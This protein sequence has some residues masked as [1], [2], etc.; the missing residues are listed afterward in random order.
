MERSVEYPMNNR[1]ITS[2]FSQYGGICDFIPKKTYTLP[3]ALSYS[4]IL[5][6]VF[7]S[8]HILIYILC[9][10]ILIL[11]I[12]GEI[13][14]DNHIKSLLFNLLQTLNYGGNIR[15]TRGLPVGNLE[16]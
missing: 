10:L 12:K 14:G 9:I 3:T 4:C 11:I 2:V 5:K 8:L 16:A 15:V 13:Y 7:S 1:W 6:I